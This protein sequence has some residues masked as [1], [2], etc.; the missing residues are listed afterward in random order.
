MIWDRWDDAMDDL[1]DD[2][3]D[4]KRKIGE[5]EER[6]TQLGIDVPPRNKGGKR[7][8]KDHNEMYQNK[9]LEVIALEARK[10]SLQ[11]LLDQE[12]KQRGANP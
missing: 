7:D 10:S 8:A 3:F 1:R 5:L 6:L 4:L 9:S 11:K 2:E 12:L